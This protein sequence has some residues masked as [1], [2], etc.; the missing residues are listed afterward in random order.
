M[1]DYFSDINN[2]VKL[3][4]DGE[5]PVLFHASQYDT[6][7]IFNVHIVDQGEDWTIDE[8]YT[9]TLNA[10]KPDGNVYTQALTTTSSYAQIVTDDQLTAVAGNV[11]CE[12]RFA[13]EYNEDIGTANFVI[14]VERSP[15][16]GG[17]VSDSVIGATQ[18]AIAELQT[19]L[20]SIESVLA[21]YTSA[22]A[23]SA[24][25]AATSAEAAAKNA[26]LAESWAVGG[27]GT[28]D[29]EDTD[30]AKYY[31]QQAASSADTAEESA[32]NAATSVIS[33]ALGGLTFEVD[34]DDGH[35][36]VSYTAD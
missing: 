25:E 9:A 24:E 27:T 7:R 17:V 6:G 22:A 8:G 12:V 11:L 5:K 26:T 30:N 16:D 13:S 4:P 23:A 32:T 15:L 10:V 18:T 14:R 1:S 33:A 20:S 2:D 34:A 21:S 19:E 3:V 35:V 36:T 29:D 31:A 28:R